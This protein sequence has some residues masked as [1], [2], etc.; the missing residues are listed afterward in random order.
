MQYLDSL[1]QL[2]WSWGDDTTSAIFPSIFLVTNTTVVMESA[3]H[4]ILKLACTIA[5]LAGSE[6]SISSFSRGA[7]IPSEV[8][9]GIITL[10]ILSDLLFDISLIVIVNL[11]TG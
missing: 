4:R 8:E 11:F 2:R 9:D 1:R 6:D 5:D 10:R 3:C 7:A